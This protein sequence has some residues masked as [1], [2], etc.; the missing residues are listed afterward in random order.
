MSEP[1]LVT[2]VLDL[3][4]ASRDDFI[5]A[6]RELMA[7]THPEPGCEHYSFSA[8]LDD[9]GRFHI[10]ERWASKDEMDAHSAS[11]HLAAFMAKL[12]ALGVRGGSLTQ[13]TGATGTRLM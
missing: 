12:G 5:A 9:P 11:A 3:D 2:G 13:W 10:S 4:P 6:C 7:A 1:I 8:D